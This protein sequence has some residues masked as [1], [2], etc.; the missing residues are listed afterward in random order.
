MALCLINGEMARRE[1]TCISDDWTASRLAM[2]HP[3]SVSC[4]L[5]AARS[6][7]PLSMKWSRSLMAKCA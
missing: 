6:D 2:G 4:L 5:A 1:T 3:G 7:K